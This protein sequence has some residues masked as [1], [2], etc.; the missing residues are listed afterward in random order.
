MPLEATLHEEHERRQ[1]DIRA[2][3]A[4]LA[5]KGRLYERN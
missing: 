2:D 1:F 4:E 3:N 5:K